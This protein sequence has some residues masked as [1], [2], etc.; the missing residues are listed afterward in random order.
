MIFVDCN[1]NKTLQNW[2]EFFILMDHYKSA[3]SKKIKKCLG[4]N[5]WSITC[6]RNHARL[7]DFL[8]VLMIY[9]HDESFKIIGVFN[10]YTMLSLTSCKG[11]F[12]DPE[13]MLFNC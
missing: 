13:M 12:L 3:S 2:L 8:F 4:K 6:M 11:R 7:V 9:Q 1:G 5:H 10:Y